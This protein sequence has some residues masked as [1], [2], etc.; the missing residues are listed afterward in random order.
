[1]PKVEMT[2]HTLN[3]RA[4]DF[5]RLQEAFTPPG[6]GPTIRFIVAQYVDRLDAGVVSAAERIQI[7]ESALDE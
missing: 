1:M 4:G 2:K 7:E 5:Q 6:A 3:L